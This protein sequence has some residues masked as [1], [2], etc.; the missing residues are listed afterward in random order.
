M[1]KG[2]PCAKRCCDPWR[3][4]HP[5][6]T[7]LEATVERQGQRIEQLEKELDRL[8]TSFL[9]ALDEKRMLLDLLRCHR[10]QRET[11]EHLMELA[12][13][14]AYGHALEDE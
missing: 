14:V 3:E 9:K 8:N 6:R 7:A 1:S 10:S 11:D 5:W 13:V 2:H 12:R 4:E